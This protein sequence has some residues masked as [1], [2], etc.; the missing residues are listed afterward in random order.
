MD[1]VRAP[2]V[3]VDESGEELYSSLL[4]L[5]KKAMWMGAKMPLYSASDNRTGMRGAEEPT[6]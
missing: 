3:Y 6:A 5:I 2:V 4:P 1:G